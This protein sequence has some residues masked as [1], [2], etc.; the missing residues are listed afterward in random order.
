MGC[1]RDL[2]ARGTGEVALI[3]FVVIVGSV[4]SWLV[5]KH[6]V[7]KGFPFYGSVSVFRLSTLTMLLGD[8]KAVK[9]KRFP[10]CGLGWAR[11]STLNVVIV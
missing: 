11:S 8:P 10:K 1:L 4:F 5:P 7:F 3:C 2:F 9:G 6:V